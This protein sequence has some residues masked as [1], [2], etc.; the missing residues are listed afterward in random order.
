MPTWPWPCAATPSAGC[1][2]E[3]RLL[4]MSATLDGRAGRRPARRSAGDPLQRAQL[5]GAQSTICRAIRQGPLVDTVTA[6]GVRRALRE[7]P[8]DLLVFLPGA[9]EIRRCARHCSPTW[10]GSISARSTATSL[11]PPRS[12]PCSRGQ[13][14]RVVLATNIAETSLTIE[15]V[16]A[17]VDSGFER[18][19]RF[20]AGGRHHPA[21]AG[22]HFQ[23][24]AEQR[25]G[26]AGRLGPGVCYRL[27]SERTHGALLPA[28]PP[29]IRQADLAPLALDL[30][31]WGVSEADDAG[32]ARSAAGR[33]SAGAREL[34]QRL[35][36]LDERQRLTAL[37]RRGCRIAAAPAPGPAVAGG[38]APPARLPLGCDLVALLGERDLCA[39]R[40]AAAASLAQ[41]SA[42][43]PG[44][45]APRAT[46]NRGGWR[47]CAGR[48]PSGGSAAARATPGR[49]GG[50][51]RQPPAGRGL[52]R[53]HRACAASPAGE[54]Y[55]LASGRGARLGPR[56]AVPHP[57]F[58]VAAE[59]RGISGRG[60]GDRAGR[61]AWRGPTSR[62]S[63]PDGSAGGARWPGT[64]PRG[65]GDRP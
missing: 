34:L 65:A 31:R 63:L 24:S 51:H 33:G 56:S 10:T 36:L 18:R 62:S 5:S 12:R 61:G 38:R 9:G 50:R 42:R 46:A 28:T 4:V 1:A 20:D 60:S 49:P 44:A 47:P 26:R 41:R 14:R 6:A 54:R 21:G 13:R 30:A 32:V 64:R 45:A 29:E 22:A 8:G 19:P 55:L 3:L 23:A 53:P 7:T 27:W 39:T 58:L 35:G 57:E 48:R 43:A 52:S 59:L 40:L 37:G 25:A 2:P 16:G 15:G 11:L 17:V